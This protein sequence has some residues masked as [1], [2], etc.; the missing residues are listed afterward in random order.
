ME[1]KVIIEPIINKTDYYMVNIAG[2]DLGVLERSQLRQIIG[3]LD[4][5]IS[6]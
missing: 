4:N 6:I 2:F 1:I 3:K 5:A